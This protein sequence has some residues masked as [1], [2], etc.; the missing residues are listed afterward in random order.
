MKKFLFLL[1]VSASVTA[2]SQKDNS[3]STGQT[4]DVVINS[5][6][7]VTDLNG[8]ADEICYT[9]TSSLSVTNVIVEMQ[10]RRNG[11]GGGGDAQRD[12]PPGTFSNC[13]REY[14]SGKGRRPIAYRVRVLQSGGTY[15][16]SSWYST[17]L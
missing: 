8:T 13:R 4:C 3:V 11:Y 12:V 2:F 1:L 14:Y 15:C 17:D 16:V 7:P 6:T 9:V 10:F 5:V